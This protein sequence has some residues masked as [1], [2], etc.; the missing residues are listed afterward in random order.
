MKSNCFSSI[1]RS[2]SPALAS[3]IAALLLGLSATPLA[4][5]TLLADYPLLTDLKD[6]TANYGP[7]TLTGNPTPPAP[8]KNGVCHNGIYRTQPNGQE[9]ATPNITKLDF[10]DFQVDVEFRLAALPTSSYGAPVIQGGHSYRWLGIYIG[11]TGLVG[12][13]HNNSNRSWSTT[14]LKV[15]QWY[16]AV[17][18]FEKGTVQL[19]IDGVLVYKNTKVGPLNTGNDPNFRTND[20]SASR[21]HNGCIRHLR[22]YNDANLTGGQFTVAGSRCNNVKISG[23]TPWPQAQKTYR[24]DMSGGGAGLPALLFLGVRHPKPIDLTPVGAPGCTWFVSPIIG[25]GTVASKSGTAFMVLPIP[26]LIGARAWWQWISF[27]PTANKLNW[28]MSGYATMV[29]GQ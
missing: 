17:L 25:F 3:G 22:I 24:I 6:T 7:I 26:N 28:T 1:T 19:Y 11:S 2:I 12:I 9:I 10:T 29:V 5:Q 14:T 15:G 23:A 20:W 27:N 8:P 16:S 4:A 21:P 18:Q 13:K